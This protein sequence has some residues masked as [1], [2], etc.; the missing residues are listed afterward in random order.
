MLAIFISDSESNAAGTG[1]IRLKVLPLVQHATVSHPVIFMCCASQGTCRFDRALSRFLEGGV[2]ETV[3]EQGDMALPEREVTNSPGY[4]WGL[5]L[6]AGLPG[7]E[8]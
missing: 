7:L 3:K 8:G 4:L 1:S 5:G 2:S 6:F